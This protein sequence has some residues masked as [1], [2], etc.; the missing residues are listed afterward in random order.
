MLVPYPELS[1]TI[2]ARHQSHKTLALRNSRRDD[3]DAIPIA[4]K[5]LDPIENRNKKQNNVA[6]SLENPIENNE[7]QCAPLQQ[8][9]NPAENRLVSKL[10]HKVNLAGDNTKR[11]KVLS[12]SLNRENIT[13][14]TQAN[15]KNSVDSRHSPL[16]KRLKTWEMHEYM[17]HQTGASSSND[18]ILPKASHNSDENSYNQ[19]KQITSSMATLCNIGNTCYLNSVVY[20][21]RFA[22]RFLH[23]LHHVC[24]DL[25]EITQKVHNK[26]KSASLGRNVGGIQGSNTRSWS[27]KDLASIGSFVDVPKTNRQIATEKLHEL[28]MHLYRNEMVESTEAFH[29]DTFLNAVQDVSSIFEGNQQQDAHEFLMCVLDSIRETCN[30]LTRVITECPDIVANGYV[31]LPEKIEVQTSQRKNFPNI[32]RKRS[33]DDKSKTNRNDAP[34]K[35]NDANRDANNPKSGSI[36]NFDDELMCGPDKEKNLE[37]VNEKIKT[38]GVDFFTEDFE[39]VTCSSTK[40]LSCE[41]ITEQKET[42]I[43]LSVPITGYENI[44]QQEDPNLFIQNLCITRE[45]FRGENKYRCEVCTGLTEAIRTVSYPV[46]PRLLI[47]QLKRFSGGM[48]KINN[49]IPTPF[50]L[51]C[52]CSNCCVRSDA[53]KLH[54][55]RLYSVITHVGATL[56]VGHYIAY[57]TSLD[58][59]KDYYDCPKDK[60]K[61]H[62]N[63]TCPVPPVGG[64][65]AEKNLGL[66]KILFGKSKATSSGDVTKNIKNLNGS[67]KNL[68]NGIDKTASN[69]SISC[70]SV[71]CCGIL[72]KN[73]PGTSLSSLNINGISE[74]LRHNS[75][76][77]NLSNSS[78][79][80]DCGSYGGSNFSK[81]S[82]PLWFVCDDDKIKTMTQREFEDLL[83]PNKKIMVTPYL[84]FYARVD[85]RKQT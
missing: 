15:K 66:K 56:S 22:P 19:R 12:L 11:K 31:S 16:K 59:Y 43:D 75:Y 28:Y 65:N 55:Y 81:K 82:E 36:S 26:G 6:T 54:T 77:D 32:F 69:G 53:E 76:V 51:Q 48:E 68:T 64:Q 84:L 78:L 44:D 34:S 46:L 58:N 14:P 60:R 18:Y 20:T 57:T 50:N 45:Q 24:D 67:V 21:L 42:M 61:N 27:T 80:D 62:Q 74:H 30:S 2:L 70:Q 1:S 79:N 4:A 35:D 71:S 38:M 39:G 63:P 5:N 83:S 73:S 8:D 7:N 41:T 23:N 40:C 25:S 37:K 9:T 52:F 33:K 13:R 29:A 47:I 72:M 17:Q 49:Y 10:S 3:L 85:L